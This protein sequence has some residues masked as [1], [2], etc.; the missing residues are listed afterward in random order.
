M[1]PALSSFA[2]FP[3]FQGGITP[4]RPCL[5]TKK[6][7]EFWPIIFLSGN[8][9][10]INLEVDFILRIS[11]SHRNQSSF[12]LATVPSLYL[13]ATIAFACDW[14]S[15][16]VAAPCPDLVTPRGNS[17]PPEKSLKFFLQCSQ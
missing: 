15:V 1:P 9:L 10:G 7:S 3:L 13:S 14:F 12:S 4:E 11:A 2:P 5:S 6:I 16:P 17:I 8:P